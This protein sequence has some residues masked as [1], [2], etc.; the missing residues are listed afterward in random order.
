MPSNPQNPSNPQGPQPGDLKI[1]VTALAGVLVDLPEGEMRGMLVERDGFVEVLAEIVANQA[2][3]GGK[4]G[5]TAGDFAELQQANDVLA[6]IGAYVPAVRKLL[7]ML[8]ESY[9][10]YDDQRQRFVYALAS[11]VERRAKA[12]DD[13]GALLA[14]YER[15]RAYHSAI[16]LKAAKTRRRT[17][18]GGDAG[19]SSTTPSPGAPAQGTPPAG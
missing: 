5:V 13:G 2:Q 16:G 8:E 1:D 6:K 3:W 19:S 7:E 14:K 17:A 10:K 11:G 4:A 18:G 15:T 12:R 9:A